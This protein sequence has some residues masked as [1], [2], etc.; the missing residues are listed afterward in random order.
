M[1]AVDAGI[2]PAL[3]GWTRSAPI[4]LL[5]N[6]KGKSVH[7]RRVETGDCDEAQV[8]KKGRVGVR[9]PRDHASNELPDWTDEQNAVI[10]QGKAR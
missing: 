1:L 10:A 8:A 3:L 5:L 2:A 4:V 7:L 9:R 6:R